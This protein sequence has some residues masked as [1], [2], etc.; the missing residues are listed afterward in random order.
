MLQL[1]IY[2]CTAL[3][4]T[5]SGCNLDF[6]Q[7]LTLTSEELAYDFKVSIKEFG[8][9]E[10]KPIIYLT[11]GESFLENELDLFIDSLTEAKL[12]PSAYYVFVS[13]VDERSGSN[14]R[15]E[16]FFCNDDYLAF[17]EQ[18]LIPEVEN[19]IGK[20]FETAQRSLI[21][22]SFGGLNAAYFAVKGSS[23]QNV[24]MLSPITY[25]CKELN[26]SIAFSE[27][28][29]LNLF[30]STGKNDAETYLDEIYRMFQTKNYNLRVLNTEGGHDFD[31][32]KQQFSEVLSFLSQ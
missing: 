20:T 15:N 14:V 3:M 24:A 1:S 26:Q 11:D 6:N 16:L 5:L 32:W 2:L 10:S 19:G 4:V 8:E 13:S 27:R 7:E 9:S 30:L 12:I 29:G 18:K 31:N 23:F 17:F 28:K 21:G 22:I 25:P